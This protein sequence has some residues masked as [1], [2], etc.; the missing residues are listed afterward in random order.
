[1]TIP[2]ELQRI[3]NTGKYYQICNYRDAVGVEHSRAQLRCS[4]SS[5][6]A[7][8][9]PILFLSHLAGLNLVPGKATNCVHFS[10][11]FAQISL[12]SDERE[13]RLL[14][15]SNDSEK[16]LRRTFHPLTYWLREC[17]VVVLPLTSL[18]PDK[19]LMKMCSYENSNWK[20]LCFWVVHLQMNFQKNDVPIAKLWS[21]GGGVESPDF[22]D[23]IFIFI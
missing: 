15:R 7:D 21:A 2:T 19:Q 10:D 4:F 23:I 9:C 1:M 11:H 14:K 6:F 22:R 3:P 12:H 17:S 18:I 16:L 13:N 5:F 20:L 8:I